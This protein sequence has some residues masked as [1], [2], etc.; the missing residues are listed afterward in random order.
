MCPLMVKYNAFYVCGV[1]NCTVK[2]AFTICLCKKQISVC[3]IS[4]TKERQTGRV[5]CNIET[6]YTVAEQRCIHHKWKPTIPWNEVNSNSFITRVKGSRQYSF[7]AFTQINKC[8]NYHW[9]RPF[10]LVVYINKCVSVDP[11]SFSLSLSLFTFALKVP[12]TDKCN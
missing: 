5:L 10:Y 1:C 6:E 4:L 2:C 7:H 11:F 3:L 12:G 8:F 9:P